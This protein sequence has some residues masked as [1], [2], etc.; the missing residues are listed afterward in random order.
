[1]LYCSG[2]CRDNP[3]YQRHGGEQA[4]VISLGGLA[5]RALVRLLRNDLHST[6]HKLLTYISHDLHRFYLDLHD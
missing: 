2:N 6:L 4:D 5:A 3:I 1:M